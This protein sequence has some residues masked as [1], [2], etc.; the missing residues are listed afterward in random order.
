MNIDQLKKRV[1]KMSKKKCKHFRLV[2]LKV[3]ER[4]CIDG[5]THHYAK[6]MCEKCERIFNVRISQKE[7]KQIKGDIERDIH[8]TYN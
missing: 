1:N 3:W 6:Y 5:I 8:Y 7:Y 4:K 2:R